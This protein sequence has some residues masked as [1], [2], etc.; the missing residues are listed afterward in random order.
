M[1]LFLFSN[2]WYNSYGDDMKNIFRKKNKLEKFYDKNR[3]FILYCII[4]LV[5]TLVLY[6]LFFI[7]NYLSKGNYFLANF[8]SYVVSFTLLFIWDQKLFKSKPKR[9]KDRLAQ[10]INFVII[11]VIGFPIDSFV[12]WL[13]IDKFSIK[14]MAAK[15]I[16]SLIMFIYNY[17]T[18]KLFIFKKN[19]LL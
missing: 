15:I 14:N 9:K 19:K 8:I 17:I 1:L 16:C 2:S 10:I 6:L 12:L 5:C 7:V 13:L 4:S 18:N 3:E 11:R